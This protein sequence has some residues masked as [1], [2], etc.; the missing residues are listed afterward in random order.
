MPKPT[1][2]P[3]DGIVTSG[4][5]NSSQG[6]AT[7][8]ITTSQLVGLALCTP[9]IA[10]T[11]A[12][13]MSANT[14]SPQPKDIGTAIVPRKWNQ[15]RSLCLVKLSVQREPCLNSTVTINRAEMK[16]EIT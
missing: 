15:E 1:P 8:L 13:S 2:H 12:I 16:T 6:L 5:P 7:G 3:P 4:L 14:N 11:V 10:A 9:P